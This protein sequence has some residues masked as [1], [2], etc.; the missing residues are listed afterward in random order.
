MLE[1]RLAGHFWCECLECDQTVEGLRALLVHRKNSDI[2]LELAFVHFA[3]TGDTS[4]IVFNELYHVNTRHGEIQD[5][6]L[7]K[8]DED[9]DEDWDVDDGI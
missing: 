5:P 4:Y 9:D 3:L 7:V 6:Q 8:S 2:K 1:N